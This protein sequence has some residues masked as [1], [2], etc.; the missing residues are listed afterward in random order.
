MKLSY[1]SRFLV[2]VIIS[3]LSGMVRPAFA[4][5]GKGEVKDDSWSLRWT[6]FVKN[7]VWW[8]TR[9]VYTTREDLFLFYPQ[10]EKLDKEGNDINSG[11]VFNFSAMTTRLTLKFTTPDVLGA[12][13]SGAIEGDFSGVSNNDINGLR[14]RLAYGKLTWKHAE[15][16]I[17]QNWHPMFIPEV[18]PNIASL[19]T[20]APFQQFNR[21]PVASIT[22]IFGHFRV[23]GAITTQ[24]DN[25]S[26]GPS[27]ITSMYMRKAKI[28][29]LNLQVQFKNK[30]HIA[31]V[32]ADYKVLKP[33]YIHNGKDISN[34]TLNTYAFLAWYRMDYGDFCFRA[35]GTYGQNLSEHLMMGGYAIKAEYSPEPSVTYT[36]TN[37]FFTWAQFSY[38][39]KVQGYLFGGFAKNLGTSDA[40]TGVYYGRGSDVDYV[41][42]VTPGVAAFFNKLQCNLET[43]Y[44]VAAYGTP[45]IMGIVRDTKAIPNLRVLCMVLYNF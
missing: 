12:K 1:S 43:E 41:Y 36:P 28:P 16:M 39:R 26:D 29:D 15:L 4:Q 42:R 33:E 18:A 31:G 13:V 8:D 40:N 45:D 44:T 23:L 20:G 32:G 11:A 21:T 38:G 7:D 34:G 35:K 17:G 14:L 9:Q 27:G 19:N 24:R 2:F 5:Q 10:N 30:H 3:T 6:G 22:G 37:N 25:A